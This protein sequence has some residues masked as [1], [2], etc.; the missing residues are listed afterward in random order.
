MQ[1]KRACTSSGF[2]Q[3]FSNADHHIDLPA[4]PI[5]LV[6]NGIHH[7]VPT[8]VSSIKKLVDWRLG[9]SLYHLTQSRQLF[10]EAQVEMLLEKNPDPEFIRVQSDIFS[11]LSSTGK[12]LIETRAKAAPG[13]AAIASKASMGSETS[14]P[15]AYK[16]Q[17]KGF[18]DYHQIVLKAGYSSDDVPSSSTTDTAAAT[19]A[20]GTTAPAKPTT[21]PAPPLPSLPSLP[22]S[23]EASSTPL[24][25]SSDSEFGSPPGKA[26]PVPTSE[27]IKNSQIVTIATGYNKGKV[28]G[29]KRLK[30][31][32]LP[33]VTPHH[34]MTK[35]VIKCSYP[36][37]SHTEQRKN[38]VDDHYF[39]V[40]QGGMFMCSQ[41][42]K[43]YTRK[44][45]KLRHE[46][47]VHDGKM[48][49]N[50]KM[51]NCT[52]ATNDYGKLMP[53]MYNSH[54]I[55]DKLQ[56]LLCNQVFS[57]ERVYEYH[58]THKH[59]AKTLKCSE[60]KRWFKTQYRLIKHWK[61]YHK[62]KDVPQFMCHICGKNF[63]QKGPLDAHIQGHS[64]DENRKAQ[65][66]EEL[67]IAEQEE[68]ERS[69][70]ESKEKTKGKVQG[71]PEGPVQRSWSD[72]GPPAS[73]TD[74]NEDA[75]DEMP[76]LE[77]DEDT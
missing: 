8:V 29:K 64:Q 41:C 66:L 15:F 23:G 1:E 55:G 50:C 72:L 30:K 18:P 74:E 49:V 59:E 46:K 7:I 76:P 53:H 51:E 16:G 71:V 26:V 48:L 17:I 58:I 36:G 24:I 22:Q 57:N 14:Q 31:Y 42:P 61:D 62:D 3:V 28:T 44:R 47:T 20:A 54:G 12:K 68:D 4:F 35:R 39:V 52:F 56:C 34:E 25:I 40:H 45:A 32:Q 65:I 63:Q 9:L 37:C 11:H 27:P 69:E 73:S 13:V 60:C 6:S 43:T 10:D 75:P 19:R 67:S 77:G 2:T 5:V 70:S 21:T 33:K 38:D